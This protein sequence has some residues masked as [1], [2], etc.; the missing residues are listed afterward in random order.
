MSVTI[1]L[2]HYEQDFTEMNKAYATL[3]PEGGDNP[4][5]TC[6]GVAAL[7]A[8]TDIEFTCVSG[9]SKCRRVA[10][11]LLTLLT[12]ACFAGGRKAGMSGAGRA[13]RRVD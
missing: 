11:C 5:R 13:G 2:S 7:P 1:Y 12:R 3:F 6:V 10:R 8:G 4:V 9:R